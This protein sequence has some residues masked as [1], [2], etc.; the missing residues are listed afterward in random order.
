MEKK[1]RKQENNSRANKLPYIKYPNINP[2][3]FEVIVMKLLL[4]FTLNFDYGEMF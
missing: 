4:I 1:G 3:D 2:L